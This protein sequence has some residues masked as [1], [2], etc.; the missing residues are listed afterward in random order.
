[1]I[2]ILIEM[3]F[4]RGHDDMAFIGN[5]YDIDHQNEHYSNYAFFQNFLKN[6]SYVSGE[7]M[8]EPRDNPITTVLHSLAFTGQPISQK[9]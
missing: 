3:K 1:M 5:I 9:F 4:S 2:F 8:G 6:L 7:S